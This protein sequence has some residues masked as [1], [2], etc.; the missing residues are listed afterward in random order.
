[1]PSAFGESTTIRL[2]LPFAPGGAADLVSR[3]IQDVLSQK[4]QKPVVIEY[5]PGAGGDIGTKIVEK[6]DPT[7]TVLIMQ[8]FPVIA[9]NIN[10]DIKLVPLVEVGRIPLVVVASPKAGIK[11]LHQFKNLNQSVPIFG[12]SA[13]VQTLSDT[14]LTNL[15]KV[16]KKN[17]INIPYK[18]QSLVLT[19]LINGNL[20]MACLFYPVVKPYIDSGQLIPLA[21][22][23]D[24]RLVELPNVSTLHENKINGLYQH[25]WFVLFSN[26]T[27]NKNKVQQ[28]Q[29]ILKDALTDSEQSKAFTKLY[30]EISK[31]SVIP[32][33]NFIEN[34]KKLIKPLLQ[35]DK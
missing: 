30:L 6:S 12:G 25:S 1:M 27:T 22:D 18:G 10:N 34:E 26:Q 24:R 7:E 4:L 28:I 19:D 3:Q 35:V 23:S 15:K 8:N 2:V 20:T 21:V 29:Q 5:H 31:K 11:S 33:D 17:I 14:S 13:G 16:T 32:P 9:N